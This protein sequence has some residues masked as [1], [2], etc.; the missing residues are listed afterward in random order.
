MKRNK[1]HPP[2]T[3]HTKG[4]SPNLRRVV[5]ATAAKTNR[6]LHFGKMAPLTESTINF[7]VPKMEGLIIDLPYLQSRLM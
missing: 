5:T 3:P 7:Q 1:K 6:Q 4:A 2:C